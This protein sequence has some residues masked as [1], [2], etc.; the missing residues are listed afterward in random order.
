MQAS[1]TAVI[2]LLSLSLVSSFLDK[3]TFEYCFQEKKLKRATIIYM[4]FALLLLALALVVLPGTAQAENYS[5]AGGWAQV[6]YKGCA[7]A[8]VGGFLIQAFVRYAIMQERRNRKYRPKED[9][10]NHLSDSANRSV[11]SSEGS[12]HQEPDTPEEDGRKLQE[13]PSPEEGSQDSDKEQ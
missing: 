13:E 7:A 6:A 1:L 4:A 12:Q 2:A 9:N 11:G 5:H 8:S 3:D 10:K